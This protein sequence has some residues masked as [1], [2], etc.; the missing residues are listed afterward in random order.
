MSTTVYDLAI[1]IALQGVQQAKAAMQGLGGTIQGASEALGRLGHAANGLRVLMTPIGWAKT[2]FI[3]F[4]SELET[5][6]IGLAT[7]SAMNLKLPFKDMFEMSGVMLDRFQQMAVKSPATTKDFVDMAQGI[8]GAAYAAGLSTD[9]LMKLTEGAVI[10]GT[11]FGIRADVMALDVSQAL[12]G[13]LT[14]KDRIGQMIKAATGLDA[15]K[16]NHLSADKRAAAVEK[17]LNDPAI[18]AAAEAYANTW[19]GQLSTLKDTIQMTLGKVG[20]QLMKAITAEVAKWNAWIS[21][22][23]EKIKQWAKDFSDAL[24]RGFSM[25]K[26]VFGWIVAHREILMK[27]ALAMAALKV[28]GGLAGTLGAIIPGLGAFGLALGAATLAL[29]ALS[30]IPGGASPVETFMAYQSKRD[31]AH[32]MGLRQDIGKMKIGGMGEDGWTVDMK[33]FDTWT[34]AQMANAEAIRRGQLAGAGAQGIATAKNMVAQMKAEGLMKRAADPSR[35]GTNPGTYIGKV[36][37]NVMTDDADLAAERTA[38][39]LDKLRRSGGQSD[40]AWENPWS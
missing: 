34:R 3:D 31:R 7:M 40:M 16:F 26:A 17:T 25:V 6:R 14:Q 39:Q 28:G 2:A 9:R 21:K 20:V 24:M 10:G 19:Q 27:V 4:N 1:K 12:R 11:A 23:P 13:V 8:A 38:E 5:A 32:A 15:K 35:A 30:K 22:H 33:R 36:E 37:I 18:K 29:W